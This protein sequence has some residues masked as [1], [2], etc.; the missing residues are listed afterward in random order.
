MTTTTTIKIFKGDEGTTLLVTVK[1][2]GVAKDISGATT[3]AV[4]FQRPVS[5]A[6]QKDLTF[7]TDGTDGQAKYV[8]ETGLID[9]VG[10]WIG[11][12][13]LELVAGKWHTTTF[14]FTVSAV[15]TVAS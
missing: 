3:K 14:E 5:A 6:I 13:Y 1:E 8:F 10:K 2:D 15:I 7:V 12:V 9:E 11:Q 4:K